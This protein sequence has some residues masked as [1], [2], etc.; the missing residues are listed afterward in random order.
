ME[1]QT[2]FSGALL[3]VAPGTGATNTYISTILTHLQRQ[4]D[5]RTQSDWSVGGIGPAE[6]CDMGV[7]L[8]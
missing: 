2:Y 3:K 4:A 8:H 6:A 1:L 5:G 7:D